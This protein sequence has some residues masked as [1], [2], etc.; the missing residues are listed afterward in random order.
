MLFDLKKLFTRGSAIGRFEYI[1]IVCG[2][3]I[4][5]LLLLFFAAA[6]AQNI[7][8]YPIAAIGLI[9]FVCYILTV[10]SATYKRIYN[11]FCNKKFSIPIFILFLCSIPFKI[12][13]GILVLL[14]MIIPGKKKSDNIISNKFFLLAVPVYAILI[15][16]YLLGFARLMPGESMAFTIYPNDR[17]CVNI[18][19]KKYNR[20]DIIVHKAGETDYMKRI[21][22]LPGEKVEI[23]TETDG[24]TYVYVN[25]E[26]L[27]EV[28]VKDKYAYPQCSTEKEKVDP[29]DTKTM[30]CAPIVVPEN[31]YYVLGDNRENSYDSRYYGPVDKK[32][33]KG[34][35]S[36]IIYPL[37]RRSVFKTPNYDQSKPI[38]NEEISTY[39]K[40]MQKALRE[41]WNP[42]ELDEPATATVRYKV[43]K[44]GQITN[45]R[46]KK[47]SGNRKM[48]KAAINTI[49]SVKKLAPLPK[50]LEDKEF[51]EIDYD[52]R[53]NGNF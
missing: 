1:K 34:R 24:A 29:T 45:V 17:I 6:I 30:K 39:M 10:C 31:S 13:C 49:K 23:K 3:A 16:V 32:L 44:D 26:K 46:I 15:A 52:F 50:A 19:S 33:I 14:L 51:I 8:F 11:I 38:D 18:F 43:K 12:I 25:D 40:N 48:N 21:V 20:G 42:L 5:P 4:I 28:Y 41:K 35:A 37:N 27:E 22:A 47:S 9:A 53:Y 2:L 36:H 7:L